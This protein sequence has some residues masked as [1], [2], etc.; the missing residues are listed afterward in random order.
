M[1]KRSKKV[2]ERITLPWMNKIRERLEEPYLIK[3]FKINVDVMNFIKP[4][5]DYGNQEEIRI[6]KSFHK[7]IKCNCDVCGE[8]K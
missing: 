4:I 3:P 6:T 2:D 8:K 5:L 1:Q 7:D